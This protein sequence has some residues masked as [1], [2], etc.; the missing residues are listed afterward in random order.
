MV[1]PYKK[2]LE[3]GGGPNI[4]SRAPRYRHCIHVLPYHSTLRLKDCHT[5]LTSTQLIHED[6]TL[7]LDV[8]LD[9]WRQRWRLIIMDTD[10]CKRTKM[11]RPA[12]GSDKEEIDH[13]HQAPCQFGY[14]A[15]VLSTWLMME[16]TNEARSDARQRPLILITFQFHI[17]SYGY[18][19]SKLSSASTRYWFHPII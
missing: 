18:D 14:M 13:E 10:H 15:T 19:G 4:W 3:H 17:I 16:S 11:R 6:M 5:W 8:F 7:C 1:L 12:C 9:T 2:M